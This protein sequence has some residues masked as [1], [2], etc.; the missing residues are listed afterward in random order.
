[1]APPREGT[2][3]LW[4]SDESSR[5]ESKVRTAAGRGD[6]GPW[7]P[8]RIQGRRAVGRGEI[9][10]GIMPR[11]RIRA[12]TRRHLYAVATLVLL[13][14][15][16]SRAWIFSEH[17]D[18]AGAGLAKLPP[19]ERGRLDRLWAGARTAIPGRLCEQMWA[20]DQ[21]EKPD[22]VDFAAWAAIS[23]DHSC[24]P[25]NL[26]ESA[27]P[28]P[29]ILDVEAVA[30]ETSNGLKSAGNRLIRLNR[31]ASMNLS[32]QK[33]DSEYT[34]RAGANNAHFLLP[35]EGNNGPDYVSAILKEG[36]PLNALGLYVQYHAA[37]LAAASKLPSEA[38]GQ[39]ALKVLALEGFAL[40]WLED[41]FAAGH[42]VGTWGNVAWRK[43][44]HD[45]YSE[46]GVDT[47]DWNLKPTTVFG[48]AN[49]RPADLDRASASVATSLSGLS[50]PLVPGCSMR[51]A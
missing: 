31:I 37:A 4:R 48:D 14:P 35:R 39:E 1:M 47:I 24:S 51:K 3:A 25:G 41:S 27:V 42:V 15:A 7:N 45:Y 16:G 33:A 10:G 26:V 13:A 29:W 50:D 34:T 49:M 11:A 44:T 20:G 6:V 46:F 18:I 17:R 28:G 36:A 19:A 23:G 32:L 38:S 2:V 43:G 21:G 40:H 30:A 8:L 5:A 22:C 12:S 9:C